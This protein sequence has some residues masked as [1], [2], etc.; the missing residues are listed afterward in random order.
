MHHQDVLPYESLLQPFQRVKGV[1]SNCAIP[2]FANLK[3]GE[4]KNN[5]KRLS[6]WK[7]L[8]DNQHFCLRRRTWGDMTSTVQTVGMTALVSPR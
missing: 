4:E 5:S 2:I 8:I 3:G 1:R 6:A 7:V